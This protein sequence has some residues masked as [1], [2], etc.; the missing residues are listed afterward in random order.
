MQHG[1]EARLVRAIGRLDAEGITC[2]GRR[3]VWSWPQLLEGAAQ[4]A[5]LLLGIAMD[6]PRAP[7][8]AEYRD[9][10]VHTAAHRGAP[11]FVARL[12]RRVLQFWRC[13]VEVRDVRG[14]VLLAG[15]VTL[16][17]RGSR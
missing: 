3:G 12:E 9:V 13:A 17:K 7:V 5:G 2:T 8:V 14:R 10:V 11:R 6:G 15:R 1:P 16:G 4:A